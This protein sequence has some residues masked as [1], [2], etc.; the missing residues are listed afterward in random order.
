MMRRPHGIN[1]STTRRRVVRTVS[2]L[3]ECPVAV[4]TVGGIPNRYAIKKEYRITFSK[5]P[6]HPSQPLS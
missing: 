3:L 1:V 6:V 4:V 2:E 5:S